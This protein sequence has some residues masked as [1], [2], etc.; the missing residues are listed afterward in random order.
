MAE[1]T[2]QDVLDR[3]DKIDGR[4]DGMDKRIDSV[5][6]RLTGIENRRASSEQVLIKLAAASPVPV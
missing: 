2:I 5:F 3:L 4:L 6:H 1:P